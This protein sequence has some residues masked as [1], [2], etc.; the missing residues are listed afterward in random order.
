MKVIFIPKHSKLKLKSYQRKALEKAYDMPPFIF[1]R[2]NEWNRPDSPFTGT[3]I[4]KGAPSG[5]YP[6][7]LSVDQFLSLNPDGQVWTT[8]SCFYKL[9]A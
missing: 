6:F 8:D 7:G 2:I 3:I 1:N 5:C 9:Q 4:H